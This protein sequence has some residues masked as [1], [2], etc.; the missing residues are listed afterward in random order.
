[1]PWSRRWIWRPEE[2]P[3]QAKN[4]A[5]ANPASLPNQK[6]GEMNERRRWLALAAA[7]LL[8]SMLPAIGFAQPVVER[9]SIAIGTASLGTT[10]LPL[11]IAQSRGYFKDAGVKVEI[12]AFSGGSK[13]LEALMGG[14]IDVASGAYSNTLTMAARGQSLVTIAEQVQC[15]GFGLV[16]GKG[17]I[18]GVHSLADLKGMRIGVSAP[19]SS[20]HMV[21]NFLLHKG[22]LQSDDV[23]VIGVGSS[24]GAFSAVKSGQVDAML[25]NEPVDTMLE[26]DGDATLYVNMRSNVEAD[27]VFAGTYPEA[28]L[29]VR[30]DF[31]TKYPKTTQALA[32][33]IVRAEK[34]LKT[35]TP[36][37]VADAVPPDQLLDNRALYIKAFN[38]MRTCL[39]TDGKITPDGAQTV[40]G[41]LRA[42]DETVRNANIKLETTYDNRFVE[43]AQDVAP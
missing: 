13:A 15:P 3:Y 20:S 18:A 8:G 10:Y 11:I 35:A 37:Q 36:D 32:T 34:W 6:G 31:V 42:F 9:P 21:L 14:S 7:T 23:S 2:R 12:S 4:K 28:S 16:I 25:G 40:L 26:E 29:Y 27:K 33:A 22:G 39:S 30:A 5:G 41:L 1:M 38:N 19:G 17:K 43:R 24:A